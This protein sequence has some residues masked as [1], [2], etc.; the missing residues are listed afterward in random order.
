MSQPDLTLFF[1]G[2]CP[3]CSREVAHYR[4]A[5][6]ADP[7]IRF[8]D[9]ASPGF[10]AASFGLDPARVHQEMHVTEGS[11]VFTGV[12]AFL[13]I[14]RRVPGHRWLLYLSR[15][16]LADQLLRVAYWLFARARPW[17]PRLKPAGCDTGACQR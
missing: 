7:S 15:L 8:V 13:A 9:I 16:P 14:W 10:D 6:A 11:Q 1:D 5:A 2:L 17:L 4:R 12:D 3:L